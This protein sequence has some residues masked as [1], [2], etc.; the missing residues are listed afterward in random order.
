MLEEAFERLSSNPKKS[1]ISKELK[2]LEY[3][4]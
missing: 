2:N 4:F 1:L 3:L